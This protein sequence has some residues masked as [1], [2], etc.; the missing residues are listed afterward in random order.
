ME[1]LSDTVVD[2]LC[3]HEQ[4]D[5]SYP[6][7]APTGLFIHTGLLPGSD[8]EAFQWLRVR[9]T[10]G[11]SLDEQADGREPLLAVEPAKGTGTGR[12]HFSANHHLQTDGPAVSGFTEYDVTKA[13]PHLKLIVRRRRRACVV[14]YRHGEAGGRPVI[15]VRDPS[16][17]ST[18]GTGCQPRLLA[19]PG[20][21]LLSGHRRIW[22]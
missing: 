10:A 5:P 8:R 6:N 9:K 3:E 4:T 1:K 7:G 16:S 20:A 18:R 14:L 21:P 17:A 13:G 22:S 19:R 11:Q 15:A 2:R 12:P